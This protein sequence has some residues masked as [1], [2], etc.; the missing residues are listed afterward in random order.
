MCTSAL[1]VAA[2]VS[3]A[4]LMMTDTAAAQ[5]RGRGRA[6]RGGAPPTSTGTQTAGAP[7]TLQSSPS[8][9]QVGTWLDDATTALSGAGYASV[10]VSYWQG[11]GATQVDAPILGV[12]YGLGGRAQVSATVPFYRFS[13]QGV[14]QRGLDTVYVS[15]K[16]SLVDPRDRRFGVAAGAVAE[17][18]GAGFVDASRAHWAV[19]LSVEFRGGPLRLYGSTGYFSR[20]AYFGAAALEWTA[21]AGTSLTAAVAHSAS[22]RGLTVATTSGMP[23]A[24]LQE[25]SVY[26]AHP[27]STIASVYVGG[28]RTFSETWTDGAIAVSGG[29]SFQFASPR[30]STT[31]R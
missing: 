30:V 12:T 27:V 13:S 20:G 14:S 10:G 28:S 17:I 16:I 2:V 29:V 7:A 22:V 19:P 3:V 21:P 1:S 8:F 31:S 11:S 23:R 26:L 4:V 18:L 25:A 9:R 6:S 24:S 5:G 15:T